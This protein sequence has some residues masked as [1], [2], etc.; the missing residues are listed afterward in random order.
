[1]PKRSKEL[2]INKV[3]PTSKFSTFLPNYCW[4]KDE[5]ETVKTPLQHKRIRKKN[6]QK[7]KKKKENTLKD[8]K[9]EKEKLARKAKKKKKEEKRR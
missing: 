4:V 1:M 9:W 6:T 5:T 2:L 7:K 8:K 3:V